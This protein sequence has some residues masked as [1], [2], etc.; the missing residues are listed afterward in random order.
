M[1][2]R[3][4]ISSCGLFKIKCR[5]TRSGAMTR[6]ERQHARGKPRSRIGKKTSPMKKPNSPATKTPKTASRR[7][8]RKK[9][10][11][12]HLATD[13]YSRL[14]TGAV[15]RMESPL[16]TL[17]SPVLV[18]EVSGPTSFAPV[19]ICCRAQSPGRR[20][21]LGPRTEAQLGSPV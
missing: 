12:D 13:A 4:R 18:D 19:S 8:K 16:E 3:L 1:R 21:P 11:P 7:A 20:D 17:R 14:W 15:K 5:K 9:D 2:N 6:I 10:R